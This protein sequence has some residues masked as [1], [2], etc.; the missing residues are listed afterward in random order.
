MPPSSTPDT[1][2]KRSPWRWLW[3]F[4]FLVLLLV[5]LA[6]GSLWYV[7]DTRLKPAPGE[8]QYT[9]RLGSHEIPLGIRK[10]LNFFSDPTYGQWLDWLPVNLSKQ[11]S[12]GKLGLFWDHST[13]SLLVLCNDC[14]IHWD[15]VAS[16][17]LRI[18]VVRAF[19]HQDK[20]DFFSGTISLGSR[21]Q[22]HLYLDWEGELQRDTFS[23]HINADE[24]PISDIFYTLVPDIPELKHAVIT[25]TI[26]LG[27]QVVLPAFE[28][29]LSNPRTHDFTVSG[30]GTER[31]IHSQ[32]ACGKPS[33]L[34]MNHWLVRAV[35]SAEDQR[36]EEHPGY[37]LQEL[38]AAHD[39]NQLQGSVIRG[40]STI[41]QQTAKLLFTG[42]ER[43]LT[44]KLRELLYA[45][46]MEQTLGK[47]RIMQLYLDNAPWGIY[48]DGKI[49]CGAEAAAQHYFGRTAANLK[50]EQAVW[51]AAMLH[52]PVAEARAWQRT[53]RI[54]LG[55]A[56]WVAEYVRNAPN[57][58]P[59]ARQNVINALRR[60]PSLGMKPQTPN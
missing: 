46:E 7:Y 41:T 1:V 10:A 54:N 50:R 24:L 29:K 37:D 19:I 31:L 9:W 25:G 8:W 60:D 28:L 21:E 15:G 20:P 51:L 39:A 11:T 47:T 52:S 6:L 35:M 45:V 36:F 53:G 27:A 18:P 43:S 58:G 12:Y 22:P 55:R 49:L 14:Q 57:S 16:A 2:R 23:I 48:P 17:P 4:L 34:P 5:A 40:G 3:R 56:V 38:M 59:R 33:Q 44:R 32:S 30:L 26:S 42:S 13:Q